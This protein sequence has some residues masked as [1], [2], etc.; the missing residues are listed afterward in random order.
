LTTG[1]VDSEENVLAR[2]DVGV[3]ILRY[4]DSSGRGEK[5]HRA[6]E[7]VARER[8]RLGLMKMRL[9]TCRAERISDWIV[10]AIFFFFCILFRVS[11]MS[12]DF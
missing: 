11:S 1:S 12:F 8:M 10:V 3:E 5:D 7:A 4:D 6:E 2:N 9:A